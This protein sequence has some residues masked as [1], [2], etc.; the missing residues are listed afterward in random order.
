M[1]STISQKE[2]LKKYLSGN[3]LDKKKKKKKKKDKVS[4]HNKGSVSHYFCGNIKIFYFVEDWYIFHNPPVFEDTIIPYCRKLFP[5][6]FHAQTT[7][8]T[9][10]VYFGLL[11]HCK[12]VSHIK[13]FL[14]RKP[15]YIF[16][17]Q[18]SNVIKK[19]I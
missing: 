5:H 13:M 1:S 6:Y 3:D 8:N 9:F 12:L 10:L 7:A 17:L 11:D 4:S 15:D 2:Y 18:I 14:L 19:I 16:T